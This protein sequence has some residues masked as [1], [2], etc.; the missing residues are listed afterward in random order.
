MSQPDE[1]DEQAEQEWQARVAQ[2]RLALSASV[3]EAL[4][5]KS[6][7]IEE[8]SDEDEDEHVVSPSKGSSGKTLIPP[9]LSLQS[10]QLPAVQSQP[11]SRSTK[12]LPALHIDR[13]QES[14]SSD[15]APGFTRLTQHLTSFDGI[16]PSTST[17]N[18]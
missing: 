2:K 11:T 4:Q 16:V 1:L 15:N 12:L 7:E 10:K 6:I 8:E 13:E 18:S 9:R 3:E 14:P 5:D 17:T